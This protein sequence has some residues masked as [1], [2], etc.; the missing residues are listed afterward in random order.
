[1]L[2]RIIYF[3]HTTVKKTNTSLGL[4]FEQGIK[5]KLM[6][7]GLLNIVEDCQ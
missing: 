2:I 7:T 5:N 6:P 1:M 3:V 4:Q